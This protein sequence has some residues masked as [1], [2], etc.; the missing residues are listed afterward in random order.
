MAIVPALGARSHWADQRWLGKAQTHRKVE[1]R[2]DVAVLR[3]ALV[4]EALFELVELR[5]VT[6]RQ[7]SADARIRA[8]A[9]EVSRVELAPTYLLLGTERL[10]ADDSPERSAGRREAL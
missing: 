5:E 9:A 7:R 10:L 4:D 8:R 2:E 6:R 3:G 1:G